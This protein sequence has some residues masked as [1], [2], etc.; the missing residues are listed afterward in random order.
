MSSVA[1][2]IKINSLFQYFTIYFNEEGCWPLIPLKMSS[3]YHSNEGVAAF[4]EDLEKKAKGILRAAHAK[5]R[6]EKRIQQ[7]VAIMQGRKVKSN[8]GV[9]EKEFVFVDRISNGTVGATSSSA[10]SSRALN[11]A[12]PTMTVTINVDS[13]N[14]ND[15]MDTLPLSSSK[16]GYLSPIKSVSKSADFSSMG[17]GDGAK[18]SSTAPVPTTSTA[19]ADTTGSFKR[20]FTLEKL[21]A[22]PF[23]QGSESLDEMLVSLKKSRHPSTGGPGPT[24]ESGWALKLHAAEVLGG[25]H[26][27][28]ANKLH[29]K[30]LKKRKEDVPDVDGKNC[31]IAPVSS[32]L[33]GSSD[34]LIIIVFNWSV[35]ATAMVFY[36]LLFYNL[37][38]IIFYF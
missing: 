23:L 38:F 9:R 30:L 29:S 20:N 1:K 12:V 13:D 11:F 32:L 8:A 16:Q 6:E 18:L 21:Q 27:A 4:I 10:G 19:A 5:Q 31:S 22:S 28:T 15:V 34:D 2:N 24:T 33:L 7:S 25:K 14:K 3:A 37:L 35:H 26:H 36:S 17:K